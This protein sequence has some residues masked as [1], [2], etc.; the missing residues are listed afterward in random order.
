MRQVYYSTFMLGP[1]DA[2][3][4]PSV[5]DFASVCRAWLGKSRTGVE[6]AKVDAL[7]TDLGASFE[8]QVYRLGL[9][10]TLES[11]RFTDESNDCFAIRF[12]HPDFLDDSVSW[13]V[14]VCLA[15][16]KSTLRSRVAVAA[17]LGRESTRL[18]PLGALPS[19][20]TIVRD[21]VSRWGGH[22]HFAVSRTAETITGE[23]AKKLVNLIRDPERQMPVLYISARNSD[24]KTLVSPDE[25]AD[26]LVGLCHVIAAANRFTSLDLRDSLDHAFNCWDGAVRIYWPG[27]TESDNPL[28]HR[29][30]TPER[31]LQIQ[32]SNRVGFKGFILGF[33][34]TIAVNRHVHGLASW[35]A[36]EAL[37]GKRLR[38]KLLDAGDYIALV[39]SVDGDLK[40]LQDE[41][42]RL[43]LQ[44]LEA[45][46]RA[47]TEANK[48]ESWR[49]A[50]EGSQRTVPQATSEASASMPPPSTVRE[51]VDRVA[52]QFEG[53]IV[54]MENSASDIDSNPFEDCHSLYKALCFLA[55]TYVKAK[56]GEVACADLASACKQASGFTYSAHQSEVT[57]GQNRGDYET[58]WKGRKVTLKEHIKKGSNREARYAIR[59]AFFYDDKDKVVVLGFIGQHQTTSAS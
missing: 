29:L 16:D 46:E 5:L 52:S 6:P 11:V 36:I 12:K 14:E 56:S 8:R 3:V 30:W 43:Q 21:I 35:S 49:L 57:I 28:R 33:V 17:N 27:F 51:A 55:T 47:E 22:E 34:A 18:S 24:D 59:V 9:K 25:V 53:K 58:A 7:P 41:N 39:E 31:V 4:N 40:R 20:P 44:L 48:A 54:L 38:A 10:S 45:N 42:H 32:N 2:P 26:Q 50:Y 19:R 1:K 23:D 37:H 15:T 13:L